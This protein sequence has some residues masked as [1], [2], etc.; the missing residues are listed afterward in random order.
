MSATVR[1][2]WRIGFCGW[3][4]LTLLCLLWADQA[5]AHARLMKSDPSADALLSSSPRI[6]T[7]W[8]NEAPE[9]AFSSIQLFDEKGAAVTSEKLTRTAPNGLEISIPSTLP[10]G[11]YEVRYRI[12][13]VDGHHIN[14]KFGFRV[15]TTDE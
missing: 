15:G 3:L 8:F 9:A 1:Q 10:P 11:E 7:L 2:V 6:I 14:G 4:G 5:N 13:S 12:L